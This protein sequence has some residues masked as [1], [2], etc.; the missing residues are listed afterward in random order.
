MP[1]GDILYF[2]KTQNIPLSAVKCSPHFDTTKERVSKGNAMC[3]LGWKDK[4]RWESGK[5]KKTPFDDSDAYMWMLNLSKVGYYVIDIDV[6]GN[7]SAKDILLPDMYDNLY[8]ASEYVVETGSKG[9]HFYY[10]LPAD[11]TDK[12]KNKINVEGLKVFFK[13]E[14]DGSVDIIFDSILTE[15]SSY[16]FE[17]ITYKYVNIKP[18][19]GINE[20]SESETVWSI[21]E[22]FALNTSKPKNVIINPTQNNENDIEM[23][24]LVEHM[25]NIPN[26]KRNWDEWYK[27]GQT[28]YNILKHDGLDL[29]MKW[30]AKSPY[31]NEQNVNKLWRGLTERNDGTGRSFGS[32]LYLS[33]EA[34]AKMYAII[35][36]KYA[37]LTYKSL[38]ELVEVNHF[39]IQEPKPMYVREKIFGLIEYTPANFKELFMCVNYPIVT[40]TGAKKIESF[41]SNWAKDPEKRGYSR[42]GFYPDESKCPIGEFN[43]FCPAKA[44]LLDESDVDL[45]PILD[46]INI[47]ANHDE[48]S[49]KFLLQFLAQIVQQPAILPGIA[50]LLYSE[51]GAGKDIL[52]DWFGDYI[53]G[54]HQYY[55]VGD[56]CNAFKGFNKL[57][58]GKL[59][60]HA[61]E[62]CKQT[63]TKAKMEDWK[64][65]ITNGTITIEKKGVDSTS[66]RSFC[67]SI[68]TTNNLDS[69]K[70]SGTDR[71]FVVFHSSSEKRKDK[72]YFD[73]LYAFLQ[74]EEVQSSFYKYLMDVDISDFHHT[75]RPETE[76]YK[77]MKQNSIDKVLIWILNSEDDFNEERLKATEWLQ[78][79]NDWAERNKF[80][81]HN[82]TSFGIVMNTYISKN[83]IKKVIPGRIS[84]YI[85]KRSAVLEWMGKEGLLDEE[86]KEDE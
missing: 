43:S 33:K 38:K 7:N 39:F 66:E 36:N 81:P 35:R 27:M 49:A 48:A 32:I 18:G 17:D 75:K 56:I 22:K 55:K 8:N 30:S 83:I 79:Y 29:F 15:G 14:N 57:M 1:I 37:P 25:D 64:R 4:G 63:L 41:Y 82:V 53:L 68:A 67:R 76:M 84:H 51:E 40:M 80:A 46:H 2:A 20:V 47:M 54:S 31:H 60:L 21:V 42:I 74:K 11:V 86:K 73:T 3:H 71:R 34:D 65:L 10:K 78:K 72:M 61:D 6:K 44:S 12:L 52:I 24:E 70:V 9:L 23:D 77:E 45:Q 59:L 16:T 28:L 19:S 58:S 13:D 26:E 85:I 69:L 50:I 62:V 5:A